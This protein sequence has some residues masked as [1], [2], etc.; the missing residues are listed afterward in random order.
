MIPTNSVALRFQLCH[1]IRWLSALLYLH[2]LTLP[3]PNTHT[4]HG[5]IQ[6]REGALVRELLRPL[7]YRWEIA[8]LMRVVPAI[9]PQVP[10]HHGRGLQSG[11][12]SAEDRLAEI[13]EAMSHVAHADGFAVDG[14]VNP[15]AEHVLAADVVRQDNKGRMGMGDEKR[16][17]QCSWWK[18]EMQRVP[19]LWMSSLAIASGRR[20]ASRRAG[21]ETKPL[22]SGTC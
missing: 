14:V 2:H 20:P 3:Q 17:R 22:P 18:T 6:G 1:W 5:L 11:I 8:T 19:S 10:L 12:R 13:V 16:T 4:S 7:E 15:L 9:N 21:R